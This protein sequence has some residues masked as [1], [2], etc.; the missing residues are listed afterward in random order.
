MQTGMQQPPCLEARCLPGHCF[1]K[2]KTEIRDRELHAQHRIQGS[3]ATH[4]PAC[5]IGSPRGRRVW[6]QLFL[7]PYLS[8]S[9]ALATARFGVSLDEMAVTNFPSHAFSSG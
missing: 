9:A 4:W 5:C 3:T 1:A 2:V 6:G 7:H 8:A